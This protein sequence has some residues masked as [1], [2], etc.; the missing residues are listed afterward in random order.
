MI[1]EILKHSIQ[2]SQAETKHELVAKII[3][4][5]TISLSVACWFAL[6]KYGITGWLSLFFISASL[7]A[8]GY[9]LDKQRPNSMSSIYYR[10]TAFLSSFFVL[11]VCIAN[12][13]N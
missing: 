7:A 6:R 9:V 4:F 11:L 13:H 12:M 10:M 3:T 2:Q 5:T 1:P 8:I